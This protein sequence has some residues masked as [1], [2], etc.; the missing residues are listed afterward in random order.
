VIIS[1]ISL[2]IYW[3]GK[4]KNLSDLLLIGFLFLH[5]INNSL[6]DKIMSEKIVMS[7]GWRRGMCGDD[8]VLREY[9]AFINL[10]L[11]KI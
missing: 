8:R 9:F 7:V 3:Q 6:C 4:R 10:K 5:Y 1:Y 11:R 2:L